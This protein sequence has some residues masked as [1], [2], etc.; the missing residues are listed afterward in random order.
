MER[1]GEVCRMTGLQPDAGSDRRRHRVT[2]EDMRRELI[3][4]DEERYLLRNELRAVRW[5]G[6]K[7]WQEW[8]RSRRRITVGLGSAIVMFLAGGLF[9]EMC[10]SSVRAGD[11]SVRVQTEAVAPTLLVTEPA[12]T[13]PQT[14]SQ[15]RSKPA[16]APVHV[17]VRVS[18]AAK[19]PLQTPR[20]ERTK[21]DRVVPRPLSPGEFGRQKL[22]AY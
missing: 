21:S 2:Y 1:E 18:V 19:S 11:R 14:V 3:A 12:P 16:R 5:R 22:A 6:I 8:P 4:A 7:R 15:R 20:I 13:R 17:P 9:W 10:P